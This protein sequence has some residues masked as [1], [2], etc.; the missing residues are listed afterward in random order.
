MGE[1]G[2]LRASERGTG[3]VGCCSECFTNCCWSTGVSREW[4]DLVTKRRKYPPGELRLCGGK[5]FA[6]VKR[7]FSWFAYQRYFKHSHVTLSVCLRIR[8][9]HSY[10]HSSLLPSPPTSH[11]GGCLPCLQT[12]VSGSRTFTQLHGKHLSQQRPRRTELKQTVSRTPLTFYSDVSPARWS[13]VKF[14]T[15]RLFN[16]WWGK[17]PKWENVVRDCQRW[18]MI[19]TFVFYEPVNHMVC[20]VLETIKKLKRCFEKWFLLPIWLKSGPGGDQPLNLCG[21]WV[22]L[23]DRIK[24]SNTMQVR[25]GRAEWESRQQM[26]A[27]KDS[28][29][30]DYVGV[31][32][33]PSFGLAQH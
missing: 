19:I 13:A 5:C 4:K 25:G 32:T 28:L 6:D 17:V 12:E 15:W 22:S 14:S 24:P 8:W 1:E 11:C 21:I 20:R 30:I 26:A 2:D 18:I 33:H 10:H 9:S 27:G 16:V 31:L 3:Q 7:S 23:K 29:K